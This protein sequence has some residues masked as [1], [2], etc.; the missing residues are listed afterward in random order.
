[1]VSSYRATTELINRV[2]Y[3]SNGGTPYRT[4]QANTEAEGVQL[5]DYLGNKTTN[6]LKRHGFAP[7][8]TYKGDPDV[9][10]S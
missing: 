1:V 2:R 9:F 4:L 8:G 5:I 7:D 3:E 6:I 10:G